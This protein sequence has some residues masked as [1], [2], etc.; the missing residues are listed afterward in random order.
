MVVS[1]GSPGKTAP[2]L[3]NDF[4]FFDPVNCGSTSNY[5]AGHTPPVG[6]GHQLAP[7]IG[8]CKHDYT[9]KQEQ[10]Y[11][12]PLD[13]RPAVGTEYKVAVCCKKCRIHADI[14]I[15]YTYAVNPCPNS[16]YPLHHFLRQK[17]GDYLGQ[18]KIWYGWHCSAP[19]CNARLRISYRRCRF[20]KEDEEL[21]TNPERLKSRYEAMLREDPAREGLRQATPIESL[22]RLRK[23]IKDS[24]D[25][26][27]ARRS[28]PANNKRFGEAF[29]PYGRDCYD[30]LQKLGFRYTVGMDRPAYGSQAGD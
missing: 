24:L 3:F 25:P 22:S 30:L 18:E 6:E 12:P 1:D 17:D 13:T 29:G 4:L 19:E 21:L 7:P 20:S 16:Q 15:A 27:H 10:S 11:T 14:Q 26:E 28:F 2:K 8:S 9:T 23:Y 5:L